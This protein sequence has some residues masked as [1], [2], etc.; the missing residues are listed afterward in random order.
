M[1]GGHYQYAYYRLNELADEIERDFVN[2]GA[3]TDDCLLD[4]HGQ[5]RLCSRIGDATEIEKPVILAEVKSLMNELRQNAIRAKELE[6]YLSGDTGA[7]SYL[8]RLREA[9]LLP[10]DAS[11]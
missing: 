4:E 7:D 8:R 6:W 2:D 11:N 1:S 5:A 9:G 10:A 3:Y